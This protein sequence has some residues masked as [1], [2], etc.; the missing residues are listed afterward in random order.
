MIINNF[1]TGIYHTRPFIV[2]LECMPST[3]VVFKL[4]IKPPQSGRPEED[5]VIRGEEG[6]VITGDDISIPVIFPEALPVRQDVAEE[7]GDSDYPDPV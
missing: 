2:I 5:I 4:T 7:D 1:V 3:Y 6:I